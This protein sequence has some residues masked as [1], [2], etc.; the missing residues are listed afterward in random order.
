[1]F[2]LK[3]YA[4]NTVSHVETASNKNALIRLAEQMLEAD[5]YYT[6]YEIEG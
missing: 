3:V 4:G 2:Q 1:M 6:S 5:G